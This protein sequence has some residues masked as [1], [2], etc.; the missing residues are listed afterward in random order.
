MRARAAGVARGG[1]NSY[2]YNLAR[3]FPREAE[4][5]MA[6]STNILLAC[7]AML[8]A[9]LLAVVMTPHRLNGAHPRGV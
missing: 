2:V 1:P 4:P 3:E 5:E 9:M 6:R 7:V 8:A